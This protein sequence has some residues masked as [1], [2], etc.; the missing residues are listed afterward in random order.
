[1]GNRPINFNDPT[2]HT[3]ACGEDTGNLCRHADSLLSDF[4]ITTSGLNNDQKWKSV[5]GASLVG[6][7]MK[8]LL[9]D[10]DLSVFD[11]FRKTHGDIIIN[12]GVK[13]M[14]GCET[15]DHTI[16]CGTTYDYF[17]Q[18]IIHELGHVFDK[19]FKAVVGG[20]FWA[21]SYPVQGWDATYDGYKGNTYPY[22]QH[23]ASGSRGRIEDFADMY[24]NW[25]L[26]MDPAFPKNGFTNEGMGIERRDMM[27]NTV[28]DVTHRG[29]PVWLEM[30]GLR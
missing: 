30:M 16:T 19:Q 18:T 28:N 25:V 12:G 27:N 29:M 11:A 15:D 14:N 26:D 22:V 3:E 9:G 6:T 23:P 4:G 2:G 24:M 7:K 21:S 8:A 5:L 13:K 10:D 1:V 20:E 17:A